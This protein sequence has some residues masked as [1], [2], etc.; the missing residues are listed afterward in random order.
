MRL[1]LL[2]NAR[3]F[4][5]EDRPDWYGWEGDDYIA[6]VVAAETEDEAWAVLND[7][8]ANEIG[9]MGGR[10]S[11][12]NGWTVEELRVPVSPGVKL[13]TWGSY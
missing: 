9:E 6:A 12:E 8:V 11:R 4:K 1:W 10:F 5:N 2:K 3:S 7:A 13:L